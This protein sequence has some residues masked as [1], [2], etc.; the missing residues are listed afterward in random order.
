MVDRHLVL[1]T[2]A[3][4]DAH[5]LQH[6]VGSC[7]DIKRG[8]DPPAGLRWVLHRGRPTGGV[9]QPSWGVVCLDLHIRRR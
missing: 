5:M 6:T 3:E 4:S 9:D 8:G 1:F 7:G 2:T